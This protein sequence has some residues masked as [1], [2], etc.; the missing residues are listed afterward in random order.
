M[1]LP[2][3]VK[4]INDNYSV[5][6][7]VLENLLKDLSVNISGFSALSKN[8]VIIDARSYAAAVA[9]RAKGGGC[10]CAGW[11]LLLYQLIINYEFI[12]NFNLIFISF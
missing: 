5:I 6:Y 10:E 12:I 9:N 4:K 8:V 11:C 7:S 3:K 1:D 2:Q